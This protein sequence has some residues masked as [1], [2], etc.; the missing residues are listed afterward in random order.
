MTYKLQSSQPDSL[1]IHIDTGAR[2]PQIADNIDYQAYLS[3]VA[4]GNTPIPPDQ[5]LNPAIASIN[6]QIADLELSQHRAQ[7][8][9]TVAMY[10][11][12]QYDLDYQ[13]YL[14]SLSTNPQAKPPTLPP[15]PTYSINKLHAID[16][17]AAT[18]RDQLKT[19]PPLIPG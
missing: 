15:V 6:A 9:V 11:K 7:R 3:W 17:Q 4:E 18:L 19:L 16:A 8:E 10:A 13:T 12:Q 2:I 1:I 14:T 5:I